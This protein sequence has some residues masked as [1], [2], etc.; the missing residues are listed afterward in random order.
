M[1][2]VTVLGAGGATVTIVLSSAQNAAA[3]QL[4]I[5][6]VN[7][8]TANG[9]VD[10]ITWSGSGTMPTPNN[11]LG[12]AIISTLGDAGALTAQYISTVVNAIEGNSTVIG[13]LNARSTVVSGDGS[14][15]TYGNQSNNGQV[16]FGDSNSNL[17]NF[18]GTAFAST[19]KGNYIALTNEGAISNIRAGNGATLL[20][21]D[22][23]GKSGTTSINLEAG[24][25]ATV[26][27]AGASTVPA[28]VTATTGELFF[29]SFDAGSAI[30][31]HGAAKTTVVGA[32]GA[33]GRVTLFG[34]SAAVVVANGQGEFTGGTDGGNL[35]FT[36]TVAGSATLTGG[37]GNDVLFDLGTGNL[38]ISGQGA[39]T[40]VGV[41]GTGPSRY[42]VG[43]GFT[44]VFGGGA[45]E[46]TYLFAGLGSGLIDGR[47]ESTVTATTNTYWDF[48]QPGGTHLLGDFLT[49]TD[50]LLANAGVTATI[51]FF[52]AGQNGSPFGSAAGTSVV[53]SN[54][55]KYQFFDTGADGKQD[56]FQSDFKNL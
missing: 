33:T 40:L 2:D 19:G 18:R 16:F 54:G 38:L 42:L 52:T 49:N 31:N 53:L 41:F 20:T 4:A 56:F 44:T 50:I 46:N 43:S 39:S 7:T 17:I 23:S 5:N 26:I 22:I 32:A 29:A 12:G 9:I 47:Q 3:A 1:P 6:V 35:M 11:L 45:G 51:T 48:A 25:K 28:N 24:A 14:N 36:S 27:A 55:T 37:G 13:P 10:Q 8:Q 30:I 15:L 34:G 21:S